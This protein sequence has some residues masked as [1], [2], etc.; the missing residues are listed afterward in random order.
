MSEIK[1][2][3]VTLKDRIFLIILVTLAIESVIYLADWWFLGSHKKNMAFFPILS[4]ALFWPIFRGVYTWIIYLFIDVP[5]M[6]KKVKEGIKVDVFT[7]A[8]P[9]EP[10]NMFEETLI[11]IQN[12]KYPHNTYLLDGGNDEKLIALCKK[13]GVN[14]IDSRD[15]PGAKA[16]KVNNCLFNHSDGE[17]V[18]II[19]PDHIPKEDFFHKVLPHFEDE[20]VG[21]VQVVQA[22]Y[23]TDESIVAYGAAEETFGF[24]GPMQMALN[25]LKIPTAIGANCTFRRSAL[26]KVGGHAQDLAEDALTSMRIHSEGYKSVYLPYRGSRG[27]VPAD[28]RSF[29]K[30]QLKWSNGMFNLLFKRY[31]KLFFKF[32]L[33]AKIHYLFAGTFYF[34]GVSILLMTVLPILFLFFQIYAIE[35]KLTD[36][37]L[38][39]IPYI[40]FSM[41]I[42]FYI[43]KWYTNEHEKGFPIKSMILDRGSWFIYVTSLYFS[44]IGKN[45]PYLPTPKTTVAGGAPELI[46]PHVFMSILSLLAILFV[47]VSYYRIDG[48]TILMMG[49]AAI[50]I[51]LSL[52]IIY[53][54]FVGLKGVK[55]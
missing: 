47:P 32:N 36:F 25:G 22:Y 44:I 37:A 42:N 52:P 41:A 45:I 4:F 23:N 18:F 54:G 11:A 3:K 31:P 7:T 50:N 55:K 48:G 10:Y 24:Y 27:L 26:L 49:F 46:K 38:H 8:M 13:L 39:M 2:K 30:Q 40:V 16:G 14:H 51:I 20:K 53:I 1:I 33:S 43:Q 34:N 15:I 29:F 6:D 21:F 5:D 9:G 35:M 12:I 19:D 28:L 17:F